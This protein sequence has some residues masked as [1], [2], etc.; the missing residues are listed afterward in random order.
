MIPN[1][2]RIIRSGRDDD[3]ILGS[4][5]ITPQV[6]LDGSAGSVISSKH[7]ERGSSCGSVNHG[8]TISRTWKE[9]CRRQLTNTIVTLPSIQP[10]PTVVD[11]V[12]TPDVVSSREIIIVWSVQKTGVTATGTKSIGVATVVAVNTKAITILE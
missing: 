5:V 12:E 8:S 7:V 1:L 10:C 9:R 2:S 4:K 3:P 6:I 11:N